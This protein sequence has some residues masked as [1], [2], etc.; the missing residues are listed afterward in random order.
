[1]PKFANFW[2]FFTLCLMLETGVAL[3]VNPAGVATGCDSF[4]KGGQQGCFHD[5]G[6]GAGF[7]HT[8]E[9]MQVAGPHD[10]PR[11]VHILVPRNY[12]ETSQRFPVIYFN[13]GQTTFF[14]DNE[15]SKTWDVAG[16]LSELYRRGAMQ[17]AIV[18]AVFPLNRDREYTHA[19]VAGRGCCGLPAFAAF[20]AHD[21]KGFVDRN[22]RTLA[23]SDH[24]TII[25]SSHG[26]LAAFYLATHY[27]EQFGRAACLS[28]SFWVGITDPLSREPLAGSSLIEEVRGLLSS[29]TRR[30]RLWLDWGEVRSGGLH[31]SFIEAEAAAR[32]REM[33]RILER[34]FQYS[35]GSELQYVS[36]PLGEHDESSWGRRL[37]AVLSGH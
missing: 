33:V 11:K 5:A 22:Y 28:S 4:M 9:H 20:L 36:D 8:Y 27:S 29:R 19:P 10:E 1:M 16:V 13:D 24:T 31:N 2:A 18:V 7:F 25:G 34:D 12:E 6:H 37:S 26:G 32:G 30:P 21:M 17:P 15:F 23:D 14:S 35:V 3:A